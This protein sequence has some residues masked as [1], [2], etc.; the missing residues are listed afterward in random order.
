MQRAASSVMTVVVRRRNVETC[1]P[2]IHREFLSHGAPAVR[3]GRMTLSDRPGLGVEP[4]IGRL[5]KL[6][7]Q[8]SV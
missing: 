7:R 5:G 3:Q 2:R 4:A 1:D 8:W 6:L